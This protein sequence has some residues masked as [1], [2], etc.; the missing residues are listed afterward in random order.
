MHVADA[1]TDRTTGI[2]LRT[3]QYRAEVAGGTLRFESKPGHGTRIVC[4][5]PLAPRSAAT[6]P[7]QVP[8]GAMRAGT[9]AEIDDD[10]AGERAA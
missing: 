7:A 9:M 2:G 1:A 4:D 3:M 6:A 10:A 5:I 8:H